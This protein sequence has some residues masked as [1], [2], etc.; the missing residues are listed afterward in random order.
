MLIQSSVICPYLKGSTGGAR[1]SVVDK[2]IK[3][4]AEV[5]I[6]IC[7]SR[8]HE[9]CAVYFSALHDMLSDN[10]WRAASCA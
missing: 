2:A 6:K 8:R 3:D 5:N 1:C 10:S 9:A 4:M 7:M